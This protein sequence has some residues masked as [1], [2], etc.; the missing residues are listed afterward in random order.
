[1]TR[2]YK[3]PLETL[4]GTI[5]PGDAVVI[6]SVNSLELIREQFEMHFER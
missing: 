2:V 6:F 3:T 4:F 1:M 5:G